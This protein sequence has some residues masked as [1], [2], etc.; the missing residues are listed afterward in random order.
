MVPIFKH[1][2]PVQPVW[3]MVIYIDSWDTEYFIGFYR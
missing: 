1:A 3:Y 2:V